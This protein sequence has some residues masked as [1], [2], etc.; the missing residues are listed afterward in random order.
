MPDSRKV[1]PGNELLPEDSLAIPP[2]IQSVRKVQ[3]AEVAALKNQLLKSHG[4]PPC[5]SLSSLVRFR[6][7][8][9][10][11]ARRFAY[12]VMRNPQGTER[13]D[14]QSG[15]HSSSVSLVSTFPTALNE[16]GDVNPVR[17]RDEFEN[18]TGGSASGKVQPPRCP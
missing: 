12:T 18:L 9:K 16:Q 3:Q 2:L 5:T 13:T 17:S 1:V 11:S 7:V 8:A 6:T 15:R 10:Y 4:R 14:S